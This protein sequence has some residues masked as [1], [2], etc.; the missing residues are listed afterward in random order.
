MENYGSNQ[1]LKRLRV[2]LGIIVVALVGWVIIYT[3]GVH[4]FRVVSTNPATNQV[5]SATPFFDVT[6][7]KPL[8]ERGLKITSSPNIVDS[9]A[10][11]GRVI[12]ISLAPMT[13]NNTYI[14]TIHSV[15][16]TDGETI[17]NKSFRFVANYISPSNVSKKQQQAIL[18]NQDNYS[19]PI[20]DPIMA[21][22]P[23]QTLN[24]SLSAQV[25]PGSN[26]KSG[27]VLQAQL[28]LSEADMSDQVAG[29]AQDKQMVVNYIQSLGLNPTKYNI[30]YSVST[31]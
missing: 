2:V 26:G 8:L 29:V 6:F 20:N 3:L 31:P 10:A 30:E 19:T 27:L 21:H 1:N 13:I 5:S 4:K 17:T 22:L 25:T 24:F 15:L 7:N 14:I 16:A 12:D 28:L 11:K 18:N 23:Y 9:Y